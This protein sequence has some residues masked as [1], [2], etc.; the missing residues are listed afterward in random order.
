[1][2]KIELSDEGLKELKKLKD[3][4]EVTI[5]KLGKITASLPPDEF[6]ILEDF[7]LSQEKKWELIKKIRQ[8]KD[9]WHRTKKE[10]EIT[11]I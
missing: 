7:D 1:M 6:I 2:K 11:L 5:G 10:K 8:A 4:L 9:N 3:E